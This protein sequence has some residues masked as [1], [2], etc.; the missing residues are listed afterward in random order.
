M[1]NRYGKTIQIATRKDEHAYD[2]QTDKTDKEMDRQTD[3][4]IDVQTAI[5]KDG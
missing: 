3:K 2:E 5:L 1:I 4:K